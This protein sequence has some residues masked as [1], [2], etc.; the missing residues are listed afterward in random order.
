MS[1]QRSQMRIVFLSYI[2]VYSFVA[3]IEKQVNCKTCSMGVI[4]KPRSLQWSAKENT[5][6]QVGRFEDQ[7]PPAIVDIFPFSYCS[8]GRR[9]ESQLKSESK[10]VFQYHPIIK[11]IISASTDIHR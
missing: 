9:S 6:Q 1:A 7:S 8:V 5:D 11:K 10:R 2:D 4:I 3:K